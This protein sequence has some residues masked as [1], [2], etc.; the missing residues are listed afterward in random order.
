MVGELPETRSRGG[1]GSDV[2]DDGAPV[3][4]WC[5]ECDDGVQRDEAKTMARRWCPGR[6]GALMAGDG[7]SSGVAVNSCR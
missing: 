7:R 6:P 5:G 3:V 4:S 2:D 1:D